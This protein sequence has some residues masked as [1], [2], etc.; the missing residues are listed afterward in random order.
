[1]ASNTDLID[2]LEGARAAFADS[3][4]PA[5]AKDQRYTGAMIGNALGIAARAMQHDA[6]AAD[7]TLLAACGSDAPPD[8]DGLAA[9]LRDGTLT[10]TTTPGLGKA[11]RAHLEATLSVT[12]PRYLA[13]R[14]PTKP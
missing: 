1:M 10:E 2:L 11:L 4:Q 13:R 9:A 7:R 6:A 3:V 8:I 5:L 14:G 12:N